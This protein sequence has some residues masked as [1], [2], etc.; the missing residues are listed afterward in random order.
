MKRLSKHYKLVPLSNVDEASFAKTCAGPLREVPFWQVYVTEEIGSYKPDL[1]NFEYLV[2]HA[3]SDSQGD[4]EGEEGVVVEKGEI[5]MVAQSL[6]HDHRPAK[7]LGLSSAWVS[8][9]RYCLS[10]VCLLHV[11]GECGNGWLTCSS[12][13]I[14]Q[15]RGW[16][17][18]RMSCMRRGRLG[19]RGEWVR[20]ESLRIWLR[21]LSRRMG[22][23]CR[24]S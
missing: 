5:C 7:T 18:W 2:E 16:E 4:A 11:P 19:I 1:R 17:E 12:R 6:F 8:A 21:R 13:L 9:C 20:W 23:D 15:V 14:G 24:G 3:K 10:V 22:S